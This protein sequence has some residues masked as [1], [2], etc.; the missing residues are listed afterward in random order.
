[1]LLGQVD[2]GV[3]IRDRE[4][5]QLGWTIGII[6][7]LNNIRR[8]FTLRQAKRIARS[9]DAQTNTIIKVVE[10]KKESKLHILI[11]I[12]V[13]LHIVLVLHIIVVVVLLHSIVVV[14]HVSQSGLFFHVGGV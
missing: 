6:K 14:S 5:A 2:S 1:M 12:V 4:A 3:S 7:A 9:W 11:S 10:E 13:V 8:P